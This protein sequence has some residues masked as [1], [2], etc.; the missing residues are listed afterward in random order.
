MQCAAA[1]IT[2]DSVPTVMKGVRPLLKRGK[3]CFR[4]FGQTQAPPPLIVSDISSLFLCTYCD[5]YLDKM[6]ESRKD[7]SHW[8]Q[9]LSKAHSSKYITIAS[10]IQHNKEQIPLLSGNFEVG[11]SL[12]N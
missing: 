11:K 12:Q 3:K 1:I 7:M 2:L 9:P 5:F 10:D 6:L 4:L 8:L